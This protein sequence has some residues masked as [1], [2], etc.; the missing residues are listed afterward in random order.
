MTNETATKLAEMA[1]QA[2]AEFSANMPAEIYALYMS[3]PRER[4][5]EIAQQ[6]FAETAEAL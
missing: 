6:A 2:E 5:V 3:L 1:N 4:R